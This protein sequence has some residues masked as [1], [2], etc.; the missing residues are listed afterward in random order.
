MIGNAGPS[1]VDIG[2]IQVAGPLAARF[3]R[4]FD[5]H[6]LMPAVEGLIA[7]GEGDLDPFQNFVSRTQLPHL[8]QRHTPRALLRG[9][10]SCQSAQS[11]FGLVGASAVHDIL[12]VAL[13]PC[14]EGI[15]SFI[16][17]DVFAGEDEETEI[18]EIG[19]IS[20]NELPAEIDDVDTLLHPISRHIVRDNHSERV[21]LLRFLKTTMNHGADLKGCVGQVR[22]YANHFPCV[23]CIAS[24]F[25]FVRQCP[26]VA[27]QV[28]FENAWP[29]F[30]A[31][32]QRWDAEKRAATSASV[33][34]SSESV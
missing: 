23:S 20:C 5:E 7:A 33:N 32:C 19:R 14:N 22:V 4:A 10:I 15:F 18:V 28:Y 26:A 24:Y 1:W 6:L 13:P 12:E 8:G 34:L 3:D 30:F 27:L 9:G 29:A 17:F 2:S 16:S 21:A 25:Q 31:F 11:S